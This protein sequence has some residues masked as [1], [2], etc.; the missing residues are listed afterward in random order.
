V[1]TPGAPSRFTLPRLFAEDSPFNVPIGPAPAVHPDSAAIVASAITGPAN[2]VL[3][4]FNDF[5]ISLAY[6]QPSDPLNTIAATTYGLDYDP[7]PFPIP[8]AAAPSTGSDKHLASVHGRQELDQWLAERQDATHWNA[9]ARYLFDLDGSGVAPL[10]TIA[11]TASNFALTAGLVRPEDIAAGVIDHALVFTT[12]VTRNIFVAPA[13]HGDGQSTDPTSMPIGAR[14][15]LDPAVN[16]AGLAIPSWQKVLA[17]ALQTYGAYCVDTSGAVALRAEASVG[18][19]QAD[20]WASVG[21]SNGS[22]AIAAP[23]PWASMRV[24]DW[25]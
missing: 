9:G 16:V 1:R 21:V 12:P 3:T 10:G 25:A 15:Q 7:G 8:P 18:R 11:C 2:R 6:G 20:I 5:A 17:A 19:G 14:I 22:P 24:L 23:F 13:T 4:T